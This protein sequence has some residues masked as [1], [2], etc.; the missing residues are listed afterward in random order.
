MVFMIV[1][2]GCS[3]GDQPADKIYNHLEDAAKKEQDFSKDQ[4]KLGK[5]E[6]KEQS[7]YKKAIKLDKKKLD[8]VVSLSKQ[9]ADIAKERKKLMDDEKD[10]LG[11]SY[12]EFKKAK[13]VVKDLDEADTKKKANQ[14]VKAM[15]KRHQAFSNL[16][17]AYDR[18]TSLDTKLYEMLQDKKLKPEALKK[19]VDEINKKYQA[20]NKA[21]DE[22]NTFTDQYNQAKKAFY[23]ASDLDVSFEDQK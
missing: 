16:Y 8:Q 1:L 20:V 23:K 13:P 21:K 2:A 17:K 15:E 12:D 14:A 19:Q 3:F 4:Q 7:L 22:F 6:D 11:S 18:S 9:A 5:K 10:S